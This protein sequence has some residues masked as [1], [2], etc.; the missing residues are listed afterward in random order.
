MSRSL[1]WEPYQVNAKAL[2]GKPVGELIKVLRNLFSHGYD[3]NSWILDIT[4]VPKLEVAVCLTPG[5]NGD[6]LW[7]LIELIK[8]HGSVRIWV[9]N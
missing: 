8:E 7:K 3:N 4:N 9:E 5:S 1:M 6:I 2:E